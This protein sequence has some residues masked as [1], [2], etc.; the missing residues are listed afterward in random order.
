MTKILHLR[1]TTTGN[2][3]SSLDSGEIAL[4]E[5]DGK[6]FTRK[7]DGT[8]RQ[9]DLDGNAVSSMSDVP[10]LTTA[11]DAKAPLASPTF[12]GVPAAPTQNASD[13]ST[14]I[15]T[16]AFVQAMISN[17]I[18]AAPAALDTLEELATSL[19]N[20]ASFASSITTT[21]AT[22]MN[23][24]SNLSD[25]TDAAAARSNLGLGTMAT[26]A[27]NNVNITGGTISAGT[28]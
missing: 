18:G 28:F 10:G 23:A 6:L 19:S 16:T 20:N 14:K 15:A 12:T 21:L 26:Q 8:I 13:N 1:S 3:P 2:Q 22:K 4:N 9:T 27:S 17:I 11:L 24:A 7:T 5:A 25:L